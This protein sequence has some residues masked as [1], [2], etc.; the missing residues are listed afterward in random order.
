MYTM[1]RKEKLLGRLISKPR[2]F[3]W[4]ELQSLMRHLGYTE[5][6][7]HGSRRKFINAKTRRIVSLH[8]RHP[9]D[10][11][12]EYQVKDILVFLEQ[13]GAL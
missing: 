6:A 3:S 7:G 2:D 13:E 10:T 9:D 5:L 8:K 4:H 1:G 12:L 11:L